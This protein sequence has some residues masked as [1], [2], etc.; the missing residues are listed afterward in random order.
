M[1]ADVPSDQ[2]N[3]GGGT[4]GEADCR[5]T[6]LLIGLHDGVVTLTSD[7][8]GVSWRQGPVTPIAHAAAKITTCPSDPKRA[9]LA[10]YEAG[11]YRSDDFGVAW[12]RLDSYPTT[13]AH[14]L[15]AHPSNADILYVG[16]EPA[17]V[18][19]TMDG[20]STWDECSAFR[21]VPEAGQW[22]FHWEGRHGH[23]R[24]L[25]M[26][27]YDPNIIFAGIE[28]GGVIRSMDGGRNWK[29]L[30][31]L[32][33]DVHTIQI[34]SVHRGTVLVATAAGP[35]RSEDNGDSWEYVDSGL[36]R[37]H[38][39]PLAMSPDD[40]ERVL[41]GAAS[42]ARR[43]DAEP[44]LSINGGRDWRRLEGVGSSDD[45]VVAWTWDP[46]E[47]SRAYA[48]TDAGKIYASSDHGESWRLLDVALPRVAVGA[49]AVAHPG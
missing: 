19:V 35:Y 30:V 29:Q 49:L 13:H 14:S 24:D 23:V 20:G 10:A 44:Y 40:P 39:I 6:T 5:V 31:G 4:M 47:P 12:W 1:W 38:T 8:G 22:S 21:E 28:V 16:S 46:A 18:F 36:E 43:Q 45:M 37:S 32:D 34:D 3:F 11:V 48:G 42:S 9:Y 25:R 15:A 26:A 2:P 17:S 7:D 33:P 27:P 41:V